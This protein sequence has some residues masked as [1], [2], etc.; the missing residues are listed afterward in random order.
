M[1]QID[2]KKNVAAE[3]VS[4]GKY[5][6]L[7]RQIHVSSEADLDRILKEYSS[8]DSRRVLLKLKMEGRLPKEAYLNL[9]R[10]KTELE[11][12]LTFIEVDTTQ[13]TQAITAESINR[14][15]TEFSF[16]HRLLTALAQDPEAGEALQVAYDLIQ[17]MKR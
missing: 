4:T 9:S 13:V 15:F 17:E 2:E 5:R 16:P 14:E 6:F 8:A 11:N 12:H 7:T 10:L 1:L 3:S